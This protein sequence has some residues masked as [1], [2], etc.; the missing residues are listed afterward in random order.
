MS[1]TI[2]WP[3]IQARIG[4]NRELLGQIVAAFLI[5]GPQMIALLEQSIPAGNTAVVRRA[6]HTLKGSLLIF[7]AETLQELAENLETLGHEGKLERAPEAL[8]EFKAAMQ[9]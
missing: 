7:Q 1:I 8:A 6:A 5:E 9:T 2:K 3:E 4:G